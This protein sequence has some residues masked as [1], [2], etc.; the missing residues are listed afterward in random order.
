MSKIELHAWLT[1]KTGEGID[2]SVYPTFAECFP[3]EF[4]IGGGRVGTF[5]VDGV[6]S[7]AMLLPKFEYHP[8]FI[9]GDHALSKL[10]VY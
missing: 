6:S 2:V 10:E 5:S 3:D 1:L 7:N 9:I 8:Q 4:K